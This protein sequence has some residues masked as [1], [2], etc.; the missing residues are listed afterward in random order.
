MAV[1]YSE[2]IDSP[3][4]QFFFV[5]FI[6]LPFIYIATNYYA[7]ISSSYQV[8]LLIINTGYVSLTFVNVTLANFNSF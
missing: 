8:H 6:N 7:I 5:F 3:Q 1:N 2:F 4:F